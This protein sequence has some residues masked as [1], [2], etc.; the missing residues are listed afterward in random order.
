[1]A[2]VCVVII[3]EDLEAWLNITTAHMENPLHSFKNYRNQSKQR[4]LYKIIKNKTTEAK[5]FLQK[6]SR[7]STGL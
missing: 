2:S 5:N 1:M 6:H 4:I 3:I 7:Y